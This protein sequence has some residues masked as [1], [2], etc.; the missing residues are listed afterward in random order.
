MIAW[1]TGWKCRWPNITAPSMISSDSSLASDSTI[2][3]ASCVPATTRSSWLSF[4]SS[5]VGLS[6]Y[7]LLTKATRAPPI[8]PMKGAPESVSAADAATIATMSGSFS[9]SCDSTV[10]ITWVSQR[11][12]SANSGRIGRSIRREVSVSFSVGPRSR[13]K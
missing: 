3:T 13:L 4:I 11:Q 6:T 12:P 2:S 5:M 7:S 9:W 10:M 8:G 1:I